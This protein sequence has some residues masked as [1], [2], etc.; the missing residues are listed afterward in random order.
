PKAKTQWLRFEKAIKEDR[1]QT[2]YNN[3][4]TKAF[5]V[6]AAFAER[7]YINQATSLKIRS[8]SAPLASI[9]DSTVK[10]S[11]DDYQKYY[12]KNKQYFFQEEPLRD[13]D[14]VT[15]EVLPSAI[16]Q[17][18]I[19]DDVATLYKDMLTSTDLPNFTNAN[20]DKKYD[21][22]FVKKGTLPGQLD[23]VAFKADK[24]TAFPPFEF[25]K[26]WYMAKLIDV[27]DRPDSIMASQILIAFEGSQL[28]QEKKITRSKENAKRIADSLFAILKKNPEKLTEMAKT[29][30]EYPTAKDD[31]GDLKWIKDNDPGFYPFFNAGLTMKINEFKVV[32][33][34][35]GYAILKIRNKTKPVKKVR[36][37]MVQRGISPSNQTFQDTYLKASAFAGQYKTQDA[38]DKAAANLKLN[39]RNAPSIKEMDNQ[40]QG[41]NPARTIVHWV[42]SEGIKVGD[43]SPVFDL[44]GKYVVAIMKNMFDKGQL[45]L[46]KM[47]ERILPNVRN[48]V[49]VRMVAENLTKAMASQK[50]IYSLAQMFNAKVDTTDIALGGYARSSIGNEGEVVGKLFSVQNGVLG[51]PYTGNFGAYAVIVDTKSEAAKKTDFT[52]EKMQMKN[53]F[54]S[55]VTNSA[56]T[57]LQKNAKIEDNRARFF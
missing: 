28:A 21:S 8:I 22:A 54:E 37:A 19:A 56:F 24:G 10:P 48:F 20:S 31:G 50:D 9:A 55:R 23:S 33:T 36:I 45:P 13:I 38:F 12:D 29:V 14:Y 34:G 51:G 32:E 43:V 46:D 44:S 17:K 16:D 57:T 52:T 40:V 5:Y 3:L 27:Q 2:K 4:L 30:S 49:K 1:Q 7:Q 25:N 39:K 6:P 53:E 18:R 41:L 15:F 11:D 47:K 26:S 42:Y 35:V